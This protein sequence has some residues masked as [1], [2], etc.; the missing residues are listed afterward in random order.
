MAVGSGAL[1]HAYRFIFPK[2]GKRIMPNQA[3]TK[4]IQD[5]EQEVRFLAEG[6]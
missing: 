4:Y 5:G 2:S 6:V 1:I 3:Y